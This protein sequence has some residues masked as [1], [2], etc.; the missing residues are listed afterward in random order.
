MVQNNDSLY[1]PPPEHGADY[2]IGDIVTFQTPADPEPLQGE[3]LHIMAPQVS[4]S[5]QEIPLSYAVDDGTGF[6]RVIY[7]SDIIQ[8]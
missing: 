7:T 4:V 2:G 6:P 1:G 8:R 5:G 3:I